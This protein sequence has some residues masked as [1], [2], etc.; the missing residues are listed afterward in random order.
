MPKDEVVDIVFVVLGNTE[1]V[2]GTRTSDELEEQFPIRGRK[3]E[4]LT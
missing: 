2:G 4:R 1:A 3:V